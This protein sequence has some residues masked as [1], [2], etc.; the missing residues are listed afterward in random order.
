MI[1]NAGCTAMTDNTQTPPPQPQADKKKRLSSAL[2]E[3]LKRRKAAPRPKKET[4][5]QK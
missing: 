5:D 4:N 3:N 2:R 1:R